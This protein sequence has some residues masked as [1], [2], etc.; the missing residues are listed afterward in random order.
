VWLVGW[1]GIRGTGGSLGSTNPTCCVGLGNG[2][3]PAQRPLLA[4]HEVDDF[5]HFAIC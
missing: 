1:A 2:V 4:V 5:E 3:D